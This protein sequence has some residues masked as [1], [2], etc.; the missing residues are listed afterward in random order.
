[1]SPATASRRRALR[2]ILSNRRVHSQRQLVSLLENEG[3]PVT[4]ATVSRDLDAIGAVKD[5]GAGTY[6]LEPE[7]TPAGQDAAAVARALADFVESIAVSDNLVVLHTPPGAAHLV[8]SAIDRS[9]IPGVLGTVAG[10]DTLIVVA[11]DGVGGPAV[12]ERLERIGARR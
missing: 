9:V 4:Q 6:R 10:D 2:R 7:V 3:H 12:R 8:A 11:D 5:R 1:M